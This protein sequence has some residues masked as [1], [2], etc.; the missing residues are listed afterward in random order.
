M[1]FPLKPEIGFQPFVVRTLKMGS[2]FCQISLSR[3]SFI[4]SHYSSPHKN[5]ALWLGCLICCPKGQS[6]L[7]GIFHPWFC[8]VDLFW[9]RKT[10]SW[11]LA[12]MIETTQSI[13]NSL[14]VEPQRCLLPYPYAP[15]V[16]Q[17]LRFQ[18]LGKVYLSVAIRLSQATAALGIC[19]FNQISK[20]DGFEVEH[21]RTHVF[22]TSKVTVVK[23]LMLQ[24]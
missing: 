7:S 22:G 18:V 20:E 6:K 19:N 5:T 23:R 24:L 13:R 15:T 1:S 10:E 21:N 4:N 3:F 14:Q 2:R 9:A 17:L 12:F 11:R 8:T 16:H